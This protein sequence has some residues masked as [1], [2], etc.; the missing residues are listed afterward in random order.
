MI[1]NVYHGAG[2][3]GIL[4]KAAKLQKGGLVFGYWVKDPERYGVVEFDA[5]GKA[6]S[7]EEKPQKPKSHYAA[8]G[9]YFYDEEVAEVAA[10][11]KPSARGELEITDV[12]R[13]Y[14]KK[15]RLEVAKLARGIAWL[16]TGAHESLLEAAHYIQTATNNVR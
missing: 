8:P 4:Q 16:D 1:H 14:L 11:M 15:S 3:S 12:N 6:L 13:I 5:S 7:I 2:L 9:L 10:T